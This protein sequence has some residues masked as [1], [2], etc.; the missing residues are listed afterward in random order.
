V[1]MY[2]LDRPIQVLALASFLLLAASELADAACYNSQRALP[3]K[4][5]AKFRSDPS[6]CPN[7]RVEARG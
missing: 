3:A 2:T 1:H 7:T 6:Y 4:T 5:I